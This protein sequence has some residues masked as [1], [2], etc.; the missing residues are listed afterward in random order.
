MDTLL[1]QLDALVLKPELAPLLSL[2]KGARNGI[3]Y[4]S[5]VRFPHAL[6][7]IFLFRSG[8]IREKTKL[9][10]KATRQHARNLSTFAII[11]KASM[12]LLRNVP[13]GT[14]K[15]GRYDSFFAGLLGGYAVFGRQPG[16]ISKQI[17]IYIFARVMLALAKMAIQPNMHPLSSIITPEARDKM[18]NNAYPVFASV[19]WAMVMYIWRW[20]PET[21][22]SSLRSSMVYMYV[23]LEV[24]WGYPAD[25]DLVMATRII[26]IPCARFCCITNEGVLFFFSAHRAVM[27]GV[28]KVFRFDVHRSRPSSFLVCTVL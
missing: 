4:G 15:E 20:Y 9:V 5:K 12:I 25:I 10:F 6:V 17:V 1:T 23:V 8:T 7:M 19:T 14:G 2:V 11:W 13:G 22:A 26:G 3:V 28:S 18:T 16:S 24:I 27:I 21:L